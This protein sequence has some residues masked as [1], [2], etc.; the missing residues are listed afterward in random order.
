MEEEYPLFDGAL[1]TLKE[2]EEKLIPLK[3][4]EINFNEEEINNLKTMGITENPYDQVFYEYNPRILQLKDGNL[5]SPAKII[6]LVDEA[7]KLLNLYRD[8]TQQLFKDGLI[9]EI[10]FNRNMAFYQVKK[11]FLETIFFKVTNGQNI[12]KN[13]EGLGVSFM[14]RKGKPRFTPDIQG[15]R[16]NSSASASGPVYNSGTGNSYSGATGNSYSG[17]TGNQLNTSTN[18]SDANM[19]S[20]GGKKRKSKKSK[21]RK[22]KKIKSKKIK[23]KKR[24]RKSMKR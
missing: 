9:D 20:M 8:I 7:Y 10:H 1:F 12:A 15:F 23:S 22:S 13:E 4:E 3:E 6:E 11:G 21:K 18:F 2:L 5:K 17:A 16:P 24:R 14:S 19:D